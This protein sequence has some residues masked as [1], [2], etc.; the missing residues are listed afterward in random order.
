MKI[1]DLEICNIRGIRHFEHDFQGKNAVILGANGTGK[2]SILDAIDFLLTGN[3]SRLTGEGTSGISLSRHGIYVDRTSLPR[4]SY[5]RA[6]V[7]FPGDDELTTLTR[8]MSSPDKLEYSPQPNSRIT[9]ISELANYRQHM[10]TRDQ[11]LT[12]VAATSGDRASKVKTLLNLQSLEKTRST[13]GKVARTLKKKKESANTDLESARSA[14]CGVLGVESFES[15]IVLRAINECR[16]VLGASELTSISSAAI[17]KDISYHALS[18]NDMAGL[19]LIL[20][21]ANSLNRRVDEKNIQRVREMESTLESKLFHLRS[22]KELLRN[23]EQLKL[24]EMGINMV[25]SDSCPL[26]DRP[27]NKD[28]L[29]RHL[30]RKIAAASEAGPLISE[31]EQVETMIRQEIIDMLSSLESIV[32]SSLKIDNV[33]LNLMQKWKG[34]LRSHRNALQDS[35]SDYH[36]YE[37]SSLGISKLMKDETVKDVLLRVTESLEELQSHRESEEDPTAMAFA[38]LAQTEIVVAR[39]EQQVANFEHIC[40]AFNRSVSLNE[41]FI[42][43][44]ELRL[45]DIYDSIS[46][47]FVRLYR[48][49]H[50]DECAFEAQLRPDQ[51]ALHLDVEFYGHGMHPP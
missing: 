8:Y 34:E 38:R 46:D 5:V 35:V 23:V 39:L 4:Q 15:Q 29:T 24:V 50:E 32:S 41:H 6:A 18:Q 30:E 12:F 45:N 17:Q 2:S 13:L 43:Q 14:V 7:Q 37:R 11:M 20:E 44:S 47:E 16:M 28:E 31:I 40:M 1:F 9:R 51:A 3:I 49:L 27:W 33:D 42:S 25:D 26:C 48:Y 22:D 10:L 21:Q 19:S 36:F